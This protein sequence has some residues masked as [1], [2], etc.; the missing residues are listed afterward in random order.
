MGSFA[1][2]RRTFFYNL[3]RYGFTFSKDEI[4]QIIISSLV[5]AFIW[6]FNKWG[7]VT[8]D[9]VQGILNFILGAVFSLVAI[10]FNQVGQRVVAVHYGYDP[11]YE[12][13]MLGLMIGLVVTFAS[14]GYLIFFLPGGINLRHLTASRLGEFRYYTNDWEWAKAA[15]TG[16]I[17]NMLF[18]VLLS[19]FQ[20][21]LIIGNINIIQ[22]LMIMN[23]FFAVYSLIPLPGNL[24][25]YLM[26]PHYHF[27]AFICVLT[28]LLALMVFFVPWWLTLLVAP[29]FAAVFMYWHYFVHD[30]KHKA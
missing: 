21:M 18:A 11:I 1:S 8:F 22:Q 27:W 13:G 19:P 20:K 14:R 25:L 2:E 12:Y 15:C 5:I 24:G 26:Y 4:K 28:I 6:S 3:K 16:P 30:G 10:V 17:L 7:E 9:F 29:I 23:V